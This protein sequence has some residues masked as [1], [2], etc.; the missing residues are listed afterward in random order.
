MPSATATL[1]G[2][3]IPKNG[4]VKAVRRLLDDRASA[5]RGGDRA[6]FLASIDT[7][8][9]PLASSQR[10]FY[11]NIRG[12]DLASWSYLV[13]A[14]S[15]SHKSTKGGDRWSYDVYVSY[16]L[17]GLAS[18]P[19]IST[20]RVTVVERTEGWRFTKI[21]AADQ[22]VEPWDIGKTTSVHDDRIVVLGV[23]TP[24]AKLRKIQRQAADAV[25][26]VDDVWDG[27]WARG[28]VIVVPPD[29]ETAAK[30]SDTSNVASLAAVATGASAV[31]G[32]G[33][34]QHWD[35]IVVNPA[36]WKKMSDT[37]RSVVLAHE[38]TH[39]ATG[40]LGAV[41]IWLSEGLADYVGW[42]G[43]GVAMRSIAR[44][45]T[46]DVEDGDVP[47]DLPVER[48]FRGDDPDQAYEE[49]WLAAKYVVF[50]YGED[51]LVELYREMAK[52]PDASKKSQS[53]ALEATLDVSRSEFRHGWQ[54]YVEARLD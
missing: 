43:K 42:K 16:S 15:A 44:E 51:K 12:A 17:D 10:E 13:D 21:S 14:D 23:G 49:A 19:A 50:R 53:K 32:S 45:V 39:V 3:R 11:D 48:E 24:K 41:P 1:S 18:R 9:E 34:L 29:T 40:S 30:L 2:D 31:D 33:D 7:A 54:S 8:A 28:S 36:A 27:D 4:P 25:P 47:S 35:R 26:A 38:L 37:G 6:G 22:H 52:Q 46:K 20:E 5:L